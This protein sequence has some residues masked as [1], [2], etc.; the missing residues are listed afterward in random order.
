[1]S[2]LVSGQYGSDSEEDAVPQDSKDVFNLTTLPNAA[3]PSNRNQQQTSS[4]KVQSAPDVLD[5]D[6]MAGGSWS[7]ALTR[8]TD[9]QMNVNLPYDALAHDVQG[10]RALTDFTGASLMNRTQNTVTGWVD[11]HAM[12]ENDFRQQQKSFNVLGFARNP[13]ALA[14]TGQY[15]GNTEKALQLQ[16]GIEAD[17]KPSRAQTKA[18]KR[19]REDKGKL[20]VFNNPEEEE[21]GQPPKEKEYKGPWAA[22]EEEDFVPDGPDWEEQEEHYKRTKTSAII[23]KGKRDVGFGEEKSVFH[24]KFFGLAAFPFCQ[25]AYFRSDRQATSRLSRSFLHVATPRRCSRQP[26]DARSW[27]ARVL[28]SKAM[29][30]HLVRAH[31]GCL[32]FPAL[33][34]D[35]PSYFVRFYGFANQGESVFFFSYRRRKSLM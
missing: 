21:E 13:E 6:I 33:P 29:H 3:G 30:S 32:V 5:K 23:V 10:P 7:N 27:L 16:S 15:V 34:Q 26:R 22:Y 28:H 31:Q 12:S 20:G 14:Q 35:R 17:F 8:P 1:M 9:T 25:K 2:A 11:E 18:M 24:G 4:G 19:K